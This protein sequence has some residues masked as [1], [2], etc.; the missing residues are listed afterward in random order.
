MK[1]LEQISPGELPITVVIPDLKAAGAALSKPA[2]APSPAPKAE[3]PAI[4][5]QFGN[6][7]ISQSI[8]GG[9]S[10]TDF[11]NGNTEYSMPDGRNVTIKKNGDIDIRQGDEHVDR[12]QVVLF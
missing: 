8:G 3:P 11:S 10:K 4:Q 5:Q 12:I 9:A 2:D 6:A 1:V 7:A